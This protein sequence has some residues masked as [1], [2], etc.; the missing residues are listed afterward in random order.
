MAECG[1][2]CRPGPRTG[3]DRDDPGRG[4]IG[5]AEKVLVLLDLS[6][7]RTERTGAP[8]ETV[9][10]RQLAEK[11]IELYWR[12]TAPFDPG[13]SAPI[14]R[15]N[16]GGQAEI[17]GLILR[18]RWRHAPDPSTPLWQAR[19]G[20]PPGFET[21]ARAVEWKLIEMP[22]P[23][24]QVLGSAVH[25]FIYVP[26]W[27]ASA[28]IAEVRRYQQGGGGFDNRLLLKPGVGRYLH[29]LNG[30]LRPLLHR[31]WAAMVA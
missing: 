28:R 30:L 13:A 11:A 19:A 25:D 21:L 1:G 26:A 27:G 14:L 2:S 6:L 17:V 20:S 31:Q 22:L 5:F 18:F 24:L 9:T 23:R 10:T 4:P 8:P 7:E 3:D 12:E 15:Q 29:Q 16:R